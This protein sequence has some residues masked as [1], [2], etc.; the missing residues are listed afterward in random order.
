MYKLFKKHIELFQFVCAKH[1]IEVNIADQRCVERAATCF[2]DDPMVNEAVCFAEQMN[3]FYDLQ[4]ESVSIA[5]HDQTQLS[6]LGKKKT[7]ATN[8]EVASSRRT[9]RFLVSQEPSRGISAYASAEKERDAGINRIVEAIQAR[10]RS[11]ALK[12]SQLDP[13]LKEFSFEVKDDV[14]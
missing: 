6:F 1:K 14:N 9:N 11:Q 3:A 12:Q 5:L 13:N 8:S 4:P 2:I 10:S 7:E